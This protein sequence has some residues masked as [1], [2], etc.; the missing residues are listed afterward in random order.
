MLVLKQSGI[1]EWRFA[2]LEIFLKWKKKDEKLDKTL[3][4]N[5]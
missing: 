2:I 5:G 1:G 4:N 3:Y